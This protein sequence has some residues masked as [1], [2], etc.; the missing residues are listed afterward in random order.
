MSKTQADEFRDLWELH[1]AVLD[2]L[3]AGIVAAASDG[4]VVT[5][6]E[7]TPRIAEALAALKAAS[8]A[9]LAEIGAR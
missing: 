4:R 8:P 9:V 1:D 5:Q 3:I 2:S 6:I 7:L